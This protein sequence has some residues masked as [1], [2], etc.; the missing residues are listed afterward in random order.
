MTFGGFP[1]SALRLYEDLADDND[2]DSWRLRHRERYERDVRGPMDELAAELNGTFGESSGP[3]GVRVLGPVRD[4]R[5]SH[6]KSPYKTYQGAYLDLLPCLGL[7][8]HLD[9]HGLYASGRY[10]P[11]AG[12]EVARYRAAV[13]EEDGG[14]ELAA[15][16]ARLEAHGFTIGGD[17]LKSRPRGVP[18]DHPR[19]D[20]L[21]HRK[22]DA[23]RRF[24]PDAG[25]HTVRAADLVRETWLLVRPLLDW[26]AARDLTP[27]PREQ[28]ADQPS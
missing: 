18:A 3:G 6:D 27:R 17:R 15:V 13:E 2:R 8:V 24:G 16:V 9:R 20:L 23:G 12:A 28:G 25:L 5:M 4:T 7:W 22:I 1:P 21:R 11:Y 19:L 26:V 10:Y 14:A